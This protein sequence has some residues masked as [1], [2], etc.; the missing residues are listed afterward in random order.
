MAGL[1]SA[2]ALAPV[3]AR[4]AV[5]R[6]S[7]NG[8]ARAMTQRAPGTNVSAP[9]RSVGG[10]K[11]RFGVHFRGDHRLRFR[12]HTNN[13]TLKRALRNPA[14][15]ALAKGRGLWEKM[16]GEKTGRKKKKTWTPRPIGGGTTPWHLCRC[17]FM[18]ARMYTGT[19]R[20][21]SCG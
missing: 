10:S 8:G 16:Y 21:S 4:P 14:S 6:R 5:A 11:V 3:V 20:A 13:L 17:V 15:A 9:L 1:V 18:N 19:K 2:A 7:V 12:R